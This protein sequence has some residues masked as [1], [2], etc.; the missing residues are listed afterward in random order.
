M[1]RNKV[2]LTKYWEYHNYSFDNC[3]DSSANNED[4]SKLIK[5]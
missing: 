4:V 1:F 5:N 2:D 3:F